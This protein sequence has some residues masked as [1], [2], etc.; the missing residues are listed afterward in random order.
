MLEGYVKEFENDEQ[1]AIYYEA[2]RKT[3]HDYPKNVKKLDVVLKVA[4]LNELYRTN[5]MATYKMVSHI[6]KLA[7]KENLENLLKK[8]DLDAVNKIRKGHGIRGEN[9]K[10]DRDFYS[11][12]TKYCHFSNPKC[13][14]IYDQYV[15]KAIMDLQ[16]NN[17]AR[18]QKQE[19]LYDPQKEDLRDPLDFRNI[20]DRIIRQYG[21]NDYQQIDRA[22]WVYGKQLDKEW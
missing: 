4:V 5:I 20:I 6:Y 15:E 2:V 11:F 18:F 19:D 17:N 14:P 8:G 16:K 3:F 13:Y 1:S 7:T 12:A 22:L 9:K 21:F 10:D